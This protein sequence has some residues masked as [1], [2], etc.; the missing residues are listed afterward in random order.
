MVFVIENQTEREERQRC[1]RAQTTK[2]I[3]ALDQKGKGKRTSQR[4]R[5]ASILLVSI[6]GILVLAMPCAGF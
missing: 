3:E 6:V 1:E 5:T 2:L 4:L